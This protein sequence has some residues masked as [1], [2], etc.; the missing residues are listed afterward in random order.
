[1]LGPRD[2]WI[3]NSRNLEIYACPDLTVT[4]PGISYKDFADEQ[5]GI[6]IYKVTC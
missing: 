6:Y 3:G 4:L 1:M 5:N 2:A